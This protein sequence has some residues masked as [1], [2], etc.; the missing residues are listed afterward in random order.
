MLASVDVL[1][2][3][4]AGEV[5]VFSEEWKNLWSSIADDFAI[6]SESPSVALL[7]TAAEVAL[8]HCRA[9]AGMYVQK[10]AA[11]IDGVFSEHRWFQG[12]CFGAKK[13]WAGWRPG[14]VINLHDAWRDRLPF[15]QVPLE[16]R[17]R[18]DQAGFDQCIPRS[19][20]SPRLHRL[21]R[22]APRVQHLEN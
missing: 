13:T 10:N 18:R 1:F 6:L 16:R 9:V 2:N 17:R 19:E 12:V 20:V 3:S 7:P 22:L 15:A 8:G 21:V 5:D 14:G 11:F 4:T